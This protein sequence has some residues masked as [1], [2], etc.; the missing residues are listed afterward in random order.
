MRKTWFLEVGGFDTGMRGWG[1]E[2][3]DLPIRV[4]HKDEEYIAFLQN[5]YLFLFKV[6]DGQVVRAGVSVT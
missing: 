6:T 4:R 2:N 1:A 5:R 3:I